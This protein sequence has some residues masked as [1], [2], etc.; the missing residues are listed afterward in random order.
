MTPAQKIAIEHH[1]RL[2]GETVLVI[3]DG[4]SHDIEAICATCGSTVNI[5]TIEPH[6]EA[7]GLVPGEWDLKPWPD[8]EQAM[9]DPNVVVPPKDWP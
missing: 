2:S 3:E 8:G 4:V 5:A 1:C 6:M 7:H 9:I